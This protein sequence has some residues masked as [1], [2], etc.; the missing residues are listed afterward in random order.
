MARRLEI[1][2]PGPGFVHLPRDIEDK[3]VRE[4]VAETEVNGEW[5]TRGRN[6][7]WDTLV[8]CE[9]ARAL[10]APEKATIDWQNDPPS[11][12]VPFSPSQKAAGDDKTPGK[13]DF[14]DRLRRLNR[15][16]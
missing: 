9:V 8:M 16:E 5:I 3:Y 11:F 2:T 12:A 10:L 6:E 14:Y 13:G 7:T 15:G 1:K 4:L